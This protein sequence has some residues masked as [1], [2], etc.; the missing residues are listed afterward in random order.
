VEHRLVITA[1]FSTAE[2]RMSAQIEKVG[3]GIAYLQ[4]ARIANEKAQGKL[5]W[6][7]FDAKFRWRS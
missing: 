1:D 5:P 3:R 6:A 7:L 2:I 4:S